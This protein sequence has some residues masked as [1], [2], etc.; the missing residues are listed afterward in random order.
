MDNTIPDTKE[1][2]SVLNAESDN[3]PNL[4]MTWQ[5]ICSKVRGASH[6]GAELPNQDAIG[7]ISRDEDGIPVLVALADGHGSAKYFRS[8]R[9]SRFAVEVMLRL[10]EEFLLAQ[11]DL[12]KFSLIGRLA[13]ES[14]PNHI[15]RSWRE[16]VAADIQANPFSLGE[17][18]RLADKDQ[19]AVAYEPILAYGSTVLG[20]AVTRWFLLYI[21][22]GD[23]DIL[24]VSE[25][26]IVTRPIKEDD[27]LL[28]NET[29][30]LCQAHAAR[31]FRIQIQPIINEA[32][33]LVLVSTDGYSNSYSDDKDYERIGRDYLERIRAEGIDHLEQ[34]LEDFLHQ[35]SIGG[36]G[37]DI[38]I[39]L[40]K[41]AE[42]RDLDTTQRQISLHSAKLGLLLGDLELLSQSIADQ[43]SAIAQLSAEIRELNTVVTEQRDRIATLGGK[44][45]E[46]GESQSDI[47]LLLADLDDKQAASAANL[48]ELAGQNEN[49]SSTHAQLIGQ[50]S[51]FQSE[52]S[53]T[54]QYFYE[55]IG[56]LEHVLHVHL[57]E[58][59]SQEEGLAEKEA[60]LERRLFMLM[61]IWLTSIILIIGMTIYVMP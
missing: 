31:E 2:T 12:S 30:S 57:R 39:A 52:Y 46:V 8:D 3:A 43:Q 55:R 34:R 9:G 15:V 18:A 44:L 21:Q 6:V 28:G 27:Q 60:R 1:I 19:Q 51:Q 42:Q 33:A 17:L 20:V 35:V 48:M 41:R 16:R 4:G 13:Q 11:E 45:G 61:T 36:S 29:H 38:S 49:V 59:A 10:V 54:N 24:A 25:L 32:P 37:D 22:L 26:G 40:I 50:I 5:T 7:C 47:Q 14:L 56:S 53:Q 58:N 23:G